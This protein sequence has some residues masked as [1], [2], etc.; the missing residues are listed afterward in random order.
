MKPPITKQIR[1]YKE[2]GTF[3]KRKKAAYELGNNIINPSLLLNKRAFFSSA[4]IDIENYVE[5]NWGFGQPTSGPGILPHKGKNH[6]L[7]LCFDFGYD[8]YD[9]TRNH[10]LNQ[11]ITAVERAFNGFGN[12]NEYPYESV[13]NYYLRS[14]YNKMELVADVYGW[15]GIDTIPFGWIDTNGDGIRLWYFR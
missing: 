14:S 6:I 3:K 9:T 2:D 1:Q 8:T 11:T 13:R 7:V 15:I 4:G 5:E 12:R 10:G